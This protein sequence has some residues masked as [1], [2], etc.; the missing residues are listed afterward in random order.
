MDAEIMLLNTLIVRLLQAKIQK[1][2]QQSAQGYY[3]ATTL[4]K[5]RAFHTEMWIMWIKTKPIVKKRFF[6]VENSKFNV[7]KVEN[8][9]E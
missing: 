7:E 2:N 5:T 4:C 8:K 9:K 3:S 6:N 1:Q